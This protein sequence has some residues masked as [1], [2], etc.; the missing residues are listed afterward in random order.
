M[1]STGTAVQ[2]H[3]VKA[4]VLTITAESRTDVDGSVFFPP[5][6]FKTV[7]YISCLS[8]DAPALLTDMFI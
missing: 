7:Y 4:I 1:H 5:L 2:M 8:G 3:T 6:L